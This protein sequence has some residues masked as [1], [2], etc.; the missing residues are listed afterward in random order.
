MEIRI[1]SLNMRHGEVID[2]VID[3]EKQAEIIKK[4]DPNILCLQ[5]VDL[6]TNRVN[7]VD[8]LKIFKEITNLKYSS[9][10]SNITFKDGWYGNA[11]LS[12]FPIRSTENYMSSICS[13]ETKGVLHSKI[14]IGSRTID[15]FNTH[16]PVIPD[17]RMKFSEEIIYLMDRIEHPENAVLMGDFNLGLIPLAG[18]HQYEIKKSENY[19]EYDNLLKCFDKIDFN[20]LTYEVGK[21]VGS[22]DKV[23]YKGNLKFIEIKKLNEEISDHYPIM[24][25][26]EI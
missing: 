15:I 17:E 1:I 16:F 2:G 5:E 24:V 18:K 23:M 11:I 13:K 8:E 21:P 6:F 14:E 4:Y 25:K 26:F 20:E 22:L 7:Q 9:Y 10:G 3:V 19:P 12:E